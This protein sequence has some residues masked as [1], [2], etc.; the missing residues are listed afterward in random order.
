MLWLGFDKEHPFYWN[1]KHPADEFSLGVRFSMLRLFAGVNQ[2]DSP[3]Y[4]WSSEGWEIVLI[5]FQSLG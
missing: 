4:R 3:L 2:Q 5:I 1:K